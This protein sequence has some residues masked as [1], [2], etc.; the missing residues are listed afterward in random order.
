[1]REARPTLAL[2]LLFPLFAAPI[3]LFVLVAAKQITRGNTFEATLGLAFA[4]SFVAVYVVCAAF[5]L[6]TAHRPGVVA[7]TSLVPLGPSPDIVRARIR[8]TASPSQRIVHEDEERMI[9]LLGPPVSSARMRGTAAPAETPLR[10]DIELGAP[11]SG[12]REA[13]SARIV[14]RELLTSSPPAVDRAESLFA[15]LCAVS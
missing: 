3:G 10:V 8:A 7:R 4:G 14:V 11:A 6:G 9:L 5:L 1:M 2:A 12:Y 13:P 15:A